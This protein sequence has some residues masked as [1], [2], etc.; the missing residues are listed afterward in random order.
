MASHWVWGDNIHKTVILDSS[1]IMMCFEFSI[2]LERELTRLL[3]S[4][5]VIVPSSII[6]ELEFLSKKGAGNKKIKAKASL[7]LV[8]KYETVSVD[9]KNADDSLINLAKKM[10]GVVVTNDKELR[11]RLRGASVSVV[12][13][14]AKK[15]LMI[16]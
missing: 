6:R 3:G 2:D 1:A 7:K 14:R 10:N 13:L 12:F 11:K 8:D 16:E 9:E 5:H 4:Y 15:K